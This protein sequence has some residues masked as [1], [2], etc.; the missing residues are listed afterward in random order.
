[1]QLTPSKHGEP[2][3]QK[4]KPE[5]LEKDK[6]EN[7]S[8]LCFWHLFIIPLSRLL[9]G[10][11]KKR[12]KILSYSLSFDYLCP[13][14]LLLL[15][16]QC[17]CYFTS[18]YLSPLP[19]QPILLIYLP[20]SGFWFF[21]FLF[22]FQLVSLPL[23]SGLPPVPLLCFLLSFSFSHPFITSFFIQDTHVSICAPSASLAVGSEEE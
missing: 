13:W 3:A 4:G 2:K 7:T 16:A 6:Q 18:S 5:S 1:M 11:G 9:I 15:N 23:L 14:F 17:F 21:P 19:N 10:D 20:C 22:C 8:W 12:Q